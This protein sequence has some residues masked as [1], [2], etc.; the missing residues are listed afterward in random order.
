MGFYSFCGDRNKHTILYK[1]STPQP[2][3]TLCLSVQLLTLRR[4]CHASQ[5]LNGKF[6]SKSAA[7][8]LQ[9]R[10]PPISQSSTLLCPPLV[11]AFAFPRQQPSSALP[12]AA[13][14]PTSSSFL[15][16]AFR[17]AAWL[18]LLFLTRVFLS[19]LG[20][21]TRRVKHRHLQSLNS[22]GCVSGVHLTH[23]GSWVLQ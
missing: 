19:Q 9:M 13:A 8:L 14:L 3:S 1:T 4:F 7:F 23:M 18:A 2:P 17:S 15:P 6:H 12:S 10:L 5:H 21:R 11:S 16:G 22:Q 20:R